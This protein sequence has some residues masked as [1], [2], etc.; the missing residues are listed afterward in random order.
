MDNLSTIRDTKVLPTQ[1]FSASLILQT[2]HAGLK[3]EAIVYFILHLA[4]F[5]GSSC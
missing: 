4:L 2:T 5:S 3:Y 1:A